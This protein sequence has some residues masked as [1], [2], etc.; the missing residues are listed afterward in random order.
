MKLS[1]K[2]A[3]VKMAEL[4]GKDWFTDSN[5][6]GVFYNNE[7][8]SNFW[9]WNP[10]ENI[11]QMMEVLEGIESHSLELCTRGGMKYCSLS[12]PCIIPIPLDRCYPAHEKTYSKAIFQAVKK[13]MESEG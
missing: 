4:C 1:D 3:S 8:H 7:D 5:N 6:K 10:R 11:A 13:W 2:E 12:I 9:Q